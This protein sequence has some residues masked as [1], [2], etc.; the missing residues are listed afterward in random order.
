MEELDRR[1]AFGV[2][3]FPMMNKFLSPNLKPFDVALGSCISSNSF[4]SSSC[5]LSQ[6]HFC[7]AFLRSLTHDN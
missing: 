4:Y 7:G 3:E 2:T 6:E 5:H 1:L